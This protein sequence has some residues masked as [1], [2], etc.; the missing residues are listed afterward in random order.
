MLSCRL[1]KGKV[2]LE[3]QNKLGHK[4]NNILLLEQALTHKS[5]GTF[6]N[7]RLEFLG[8]AL[9]N[10]EAA[11]LLFEQFTTL[12][13]GN[14]SRIRSGMVRQETLIKI[15]HR[16]GLAPH[17]RYTHDPLNG[18]RPTK[19]SDAI[20]ADAVEAVYGAIYVD[21][22]PDKAKSI[23]RNH[24]VQV[25]NNGEV[26]LGKDPKTLLQEYLQ[27]RRIPVPT[28]KL[29]GHPDGSRALTEVSCAIP[30]LNITTFAHAGTKKQAE[31]KAAQKALAACGVA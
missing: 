11:L 13:E 9:L 22:G 7:E 4:F 31:A 10:C 25:L 1:S 27:A 17:I 19:L 28:Y 20:I 3:L 8:D 12:S 2:V 5:C 30:Q 6:N 14:M 26:Q 29:V 18:V 16:V 23:I 24:M 21:G 15:A